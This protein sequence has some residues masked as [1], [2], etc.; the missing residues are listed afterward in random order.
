M[1]DLHK[2]ILALREQGFTSKEIAIKLN[3]SKAIVYHYFNYDKNVKHRK[4]LHPFTRKV[5]KFKSYK[6]KTIENKAKRIESTINIKIN[7]FFK[8]G[9]K[10][11][12][13]KFTTQDVIN[14]IGP[15]P[16][17]YLT[18]DSIDILDLKSYE[19]D[20]IIPSSRGGDNSINNLGICTKTANRCKER[21]T[22]EE[23]LELC[24]KVVKHLG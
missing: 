5:E 6:S 17:C 22:P 23:F 24:K 15:N 20:H 16:V 3:C 12:S 19:F 9:N 14:K 21:L 2:N 7:S 13:E 10:M 11:D 18:G 1:S 8:K 4:S